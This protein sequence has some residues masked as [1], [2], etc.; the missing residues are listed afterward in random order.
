[1]EIEEYSHKGYDKFIL[2]AP[3]LFE[4]NGERFCNN[5]LAILS[6]LDTRVKRIIS[7]DSITTE[8][9]MERI[10][11]QHSDDFYRTKADYV[12]ENNGSLDEVKSQV[13]SVVK[14]IL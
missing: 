13:E 6:S 1:M 8:Q 12:I 4:S 9:A 2:D 11:A 5:T 14:A 3:V 10:N 7:R